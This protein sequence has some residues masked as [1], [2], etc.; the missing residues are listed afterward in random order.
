MD[1]ENVDKYLKIAIKY[2][3][4]KIDTSK[5]RVIFII[6]PPRVG[7]N[8][9]CDLLVKKYNL[10]HLGVCD[11][12]QGEINKGSKDGKLIKGIIE[13]GEIVPVKITC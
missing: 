6:G 11:L 13:K 4:N 10:I 1:N 8:T 2:I 7:K 3:I 5:Y 12:L 9:Q